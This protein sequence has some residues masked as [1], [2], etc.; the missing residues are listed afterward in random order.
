MIEGLTAVGLPHQIRVREEKILFQRDKAGKIASLSPSG[1]P[2]DQTQINYCKKWIKQF[3]IPRKTINSRY[4]SY[5][6]KHIVEE[7][8]GTYISNGAFIAAADESGY[9]VIP[10]GGDSPNASFKF[11]INI[12]GINTQR[13]DIPSYWKKRKI[14][15][16]DGV[17]LGI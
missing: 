11:W 9:D 15:T 10:D 8:Y 6:L 2:I 16:P 14:N 5:G 1:Y 17:V 7:Y 4:G 3:C 13:R 12:A